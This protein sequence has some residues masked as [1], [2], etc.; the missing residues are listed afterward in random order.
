MYTY[1]FNVDQFFTSPKSIPGAI[2]FIMVGFGLEGRYK[3]P[4][5]GV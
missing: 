3:F 2:W 4:M 1:Y 5:E